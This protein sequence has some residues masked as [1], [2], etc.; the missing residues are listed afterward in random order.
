MVMLVGIFFMMNTIV[1]GTL[2]C[3]GNILQVVAEW[4]LF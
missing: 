1:V 4:R 2:C 3:G